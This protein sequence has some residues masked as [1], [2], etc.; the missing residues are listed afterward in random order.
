MAMILIFPAISTNPYLMSLWSPSLVKKIAFRNTA[1]DQL[2]LA[3]RIGAADLPWKLAP[4]WACPSED[5]GHRLHDCSVLGPSI[6]YT[7]FG[8]PAGRPHRVHVDTN[9]PV[10]RNDVAEFHGYHSPFPATLEP[11]SRRR[12]QYYLDVDQ[13]SGFGLRGTQRHDGEKHQKGRSE[14]LLR[15]ASCPRS[16]LPGDVSK[17]VASRSQ[18]SLRTCFANAFRSNGYFMAFS[19]RAG[20]PMAT[21]RPCRGLSRDRIPL[22]P[23]T[24]EP[25][26]REKRPPK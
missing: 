21:G 18:K 2:V 5:A 15:T 12:L 19:T 20:L 3:P 13:G 24:G 1:S 7:A 10:C 22:P 8:S 23:S 14:F 9:L 25:S 17:I 26:R 11:T 6:S 4:S 16:Y